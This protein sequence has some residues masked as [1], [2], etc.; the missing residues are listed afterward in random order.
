MTIY[1]L[2][3]KTH[4]VTGLN[5]LGYTTAK[6][7]HKYKGSGTYWKHHIKKH[8]YDC[9]TTILRECSTREELA[10]YGLYYSQL[11]NIIES[12]DWANLCFE[13]GKGI[14][15]YKPSAERLKQMSERIKGKN[16]P[17]YGKP[18]PFRGRTHTPEIRKQI[19]EKAKGRP[20]PNKGQ[21]TPPEVCAKIS[22]RHHDVS[23]ANNPMYGKQHSELTKQ[24]ISSRATGRQ[25]SI[26]VRNK[27]SEIRKGKPWS[28]ARIRAA[29]INL[30]AKFELIDQSG[31]VFITSNLN[32]FCQERNLSPGRIRLITRRMKGTHRG[33]SARQLED[34]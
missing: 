7:P 28:E 4:N 5:Y 24:K 20:S 22:E 27:L 33:W 9:T 12:K 31:N 11:W 18:S 17:C 23:G 15:G 32:E 30:D 19:S 10:T 29:G 1:Y 13:N 8:G 25:H 2:Y 16:N 21:K 14:T 3:I 6:D 26:A 34:N